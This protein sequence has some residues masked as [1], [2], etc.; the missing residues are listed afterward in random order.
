MTRLTTAPV[1]VGAAVRSVADPGNGATV[2]FVGT[3]R[4]QT[5]GSAVWH[6]DYEAYV[7]LAERQMAHIAAEAAARWAARVAIE[8]RVGRVM[9]GEVSV[10]VAV[11]APHRAEAF[12]ACRFVVEALKE[13]VPIWKKEYGPDGARWVVP[14]TRGSGESSGIVEG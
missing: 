10:V 11:A 9:V 7:P 4:N 6:L 3:V 12:E 14:G 2:V 13:R 5:A 1:D 8:H